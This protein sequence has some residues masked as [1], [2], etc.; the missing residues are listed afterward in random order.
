MAPHIILVRLEKRHGVD[1]WSVET[2]KVGLSAPMV[3][4]DSLCTLTLTHFVE[5]PDQPFDV[6]RVVFESFADLSF[7][8]E[9]KVQA[10]LFEVDHVGAVEVVRLDEGGYVWVCARQHLGHLE[11]PVKENDEQNGKAQDCA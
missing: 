7:D 11:S 9:G 5:G 8:T 1:C 10:V 6:A 2:V 3:W 4:K